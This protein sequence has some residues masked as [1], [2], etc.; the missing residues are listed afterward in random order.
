MIKNNYL[1]CVIVLLIF[2]SCDLFHVGGMYEVVDDPE[3]VNLLDG[4]W[5]FQNFLNEILEVDSSTQ[6]QIEITMNFDRHSDT[7]ILDTGN[8]DTSDMSTS[9]KI[10]FNTLDDILP[11]EK[12]FYI[13]NNDIYLFEDHTN[14]P[15]FKD[16]EFSTF[17]GYMKKY[18]I[19]SIDKSTMKLDSY[20]R[21][22]DEYGQLIPDIEVT[23]HILTK[24]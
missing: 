1:I 20:K 24:R 10:I 12:K 22:I 2:F 13:E 14:D 8:L 18:T 11:I 16:T 23:E 9:E 7:V 15:D 5:V 6:S 17:K 4:T 21:Y 3:L 19:K